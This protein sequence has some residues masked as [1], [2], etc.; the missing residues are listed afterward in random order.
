V[1]DLIRFSVRDTGI[2]L[3]PA[4]QAKLFRPFAQADAST[5]RQYGGTGLG[6]SIVKRL[7]ELMSGDVGV[8]SAPGAG[9]IFWFTARLPAAKAASAGDVEGTAAIPALADGRRVLVVDDNE[10]NRRVVGGLLAAA[11]YEVETAASAIEA[12]G[13]LERAAEGGRP[14]QAVLTDH[15]MPG[16][17]GIELARRIRASR[18][19]A[20]TRLVLYSSIDDRSSRKELRKLGFAGHLSKPMRRAELLATMERVLSAAPLE[21]TQR[22]RAIVTRDVIVEDHQRRGRT[23]LLVEDNSTNRR[24]AELFLERAGCNVL[25]AADGAEALA[26]LS[27]QSVDLVLMDVQMPVMDGLE[28]TRRIRAESPGGARL[29]IVGLT[30]SALKEQVEACRAAGM[31]DVV[32]KPIERERLEAVLERYAP[33]IGTRTGRHVIRPPAERSPTVTGEIARPRFDEVTMGD[34]VLARGLVETFEAG[35]LRACAEL[36]AA[37]ARHDF[38]TARRAAHTLVGASANIGAVRLEAVAIALEQAALQQD[39]VAMRPLVDAARTRLEAALK[40]LKG[41]LTFNAR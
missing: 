15:R 30:A 33:A 31:D 3:T 36:E 41:T 39:A 26:M 12:L 9:S 35:G 6:L 18:A 29:P 17:D 20:D 11:D 16:I 10:T 34:A 8:Q 25:Q 21:F 4:Q 1:R 38:S 19:I 40:A 32:A 24:V 2:G 28:A 22:L 37:L 5:A 13:I 27:R 23:V 14:F 7:A